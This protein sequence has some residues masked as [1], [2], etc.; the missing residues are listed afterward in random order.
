VQRKARK[1]V[2]QI[3]QRIQQAEKDKEVLEQQIAQAFT[4]GE[5]QKGNDLSRRLERAIADLEGLYEVWME[6]EQKWQ[7]QNGESD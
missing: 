7:Q 2:E 5:L 6:A 1:E 3:E 4:D